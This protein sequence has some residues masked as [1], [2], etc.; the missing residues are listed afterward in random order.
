MFSTFFFISCVIDVK[1]LQ[2]KYVA[3]CCWMSPWFA[4][5][6]DGRRPSRHEVNYNE[7]AAHYIAFGWGKQQTQQQRAESRAIEQDQEWSEE[8]KNWVWVFHL[9]LSEPRHN[10]KITRWRRSPFQSSN[11]FSYM[12]LSLA[13]FGISRIFLHTQRHS[14]ICTSM[15]LHDTSFALLS[16]KKFKVK[17]IISLRNFCPLAQ[18]RERDSNT[19]SKS[20]RDVCY[21]IIFDSWRTCL[22]FKSLTSRFRRILSCSLALLLLPHT[23]V[24]AR[25]RR[26][27]WLD[28]ENCKLNKIIICSKKIKR[29]Y[30]YSVSAHDTPNNRELPCNFFRSPSPSSSTTQHSIS[31]NNK[32]QPVQVRRMSIVWQWK[33]YS[34]IKMFVVRER[35]DVTLGDEQTNE[36]SKYKRRRA[37]ETSWSLNLLFDDVLH[38]CTL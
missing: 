25:S 19:S 22:H 37:L 12:F 2:K 18:R 32:T 13:Y 3:F 38:A 23:A 33:K 36:F 14:A 34:Q 21:S 11:S 15:R 6:L 26:N 10:F 5:W 4:V 35:D 28:S 8:K 7:L 30:K 20:A 16:V 9:S 1:I 27:P 17:F 24:R 31:L 29:E